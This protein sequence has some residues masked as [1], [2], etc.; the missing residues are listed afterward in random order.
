MATRIALTRISN[1][2]QTN[3]IVID[4]QLSTLDDNNIQNLDRVF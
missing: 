2:S 3:F 1:I 4:E